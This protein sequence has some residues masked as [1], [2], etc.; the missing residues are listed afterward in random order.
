MYERRYKSTPLTAAILATLYPSLSLGQQSPTESGKLETIIVTATRRELNLQEVGQSITAFSTADIERQAL[1]DAEDVI[2]ALTS[3][4][5]VNLQPGR[6]AI[7]MRG[8]S[9]GSSEYYTDSQVSIYLDD[10]PLTSVSQ[11]VD[12]RPIDIERIESL[13]GPQGTL[14]G[15]SSQSGTLRYITN[16]P[17]FAGYSSQVDL[18]VGT[19]KGG[20]ESYDVSGHLNIP[21]NDKLAV[22]VVGFYGDEGGWV[23]NVPGQTFMGDQDNADL[24]EDDFNDFETYGGRIAA[25]WMI[26][27]QWETTLSYISQWSRA[28]GSWDSDPFLGDYNIAR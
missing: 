5:L 22:R 24:V 7:F 17:D 6:N 1:K 21:I 18:E 25:R 19:T 11:Q 3:V 2:G 27:P 14:F 13:P 9:T 8:I 20:E 26:N 15:S 28:D 12:I 16:K 10:Q 4:N 23:D